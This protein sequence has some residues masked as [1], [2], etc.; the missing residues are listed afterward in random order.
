MSGDLSLFSDDQ[1]AEPAQTGRPE[2]QIADW[3][4][5]RLRKALDARG[6]TTMA[7]R[8]KAIGAAA[9]RP[10]ESLRSLSRSEA[11]GVLE[12]LALA[13]APQKRSA[14]AWDDRH[15]ETWIDRL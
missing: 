13:Q 5:D 14:T 15:E 2:E 1:P 8:Q 6:L 10:V 4:V 3:L 12:R 11:L 7:E 9:E